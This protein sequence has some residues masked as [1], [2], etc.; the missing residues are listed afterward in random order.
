[1]KH[2]GM[3]GHSIGAV[4]TQTLCGERFGSPAR[5]KSLKD[6][7]ITAAILMSPSPSER[8]TPEFSFHAVDIP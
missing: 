2:V 4:T 7:R 8:N 3:S 5:P 6:P 1:M